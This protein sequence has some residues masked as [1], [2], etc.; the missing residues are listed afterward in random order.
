MSLVTPGVGQLWPQGQNLNK[1]GRGSLGHA[2]YQISR[3]LRNYGFRRQEDFHVFPFI[4]L[5]K[6]CGPLGRANFGPRGEFEQTWKRST[7]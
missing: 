1:L 2:A 5:C 7:R 4:G 3:M 6:T